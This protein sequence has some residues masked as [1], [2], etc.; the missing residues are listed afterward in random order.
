MW[1]G[2]VKYFHV[3]VQPTSRTVSIFQNS[4]S[5]PIQ[6]LPTCCAAPPHLS[7]RCTSCFC[8]SDSLG[9]SQRWT[10][11]VCT[12]GPACFTQCDA[13][14]TRLCCNVGWSLLP[15]RR[16]HT[17]LYTLHFVYLFTYCGENLLVFHHWLSKCLL[18]ASHLW[19]FNILTGFIPILL[20]VFKII[21]WHWILSNFGGHQLR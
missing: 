2:G 7:H 16:S 12:L 9:T 11:A 13:C 15:V 18:W 6:Q 1:F 5:L 10:R 17:A 4:H 20:S 21:V 14:R 3:I 8:R 19:L